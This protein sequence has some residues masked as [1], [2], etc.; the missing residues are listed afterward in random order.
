MTGKE[1]RE[2]K[3][4]KKERKELKLP[5]LRRS[6]VIEEKM[7]MRSIRVNV[8]AFIKMGNTT[9]IPLSE[10]GKTII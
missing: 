7:S 4:K 8:A 1:K 10:F 2:K 3:K 9:N 5:K 6:I